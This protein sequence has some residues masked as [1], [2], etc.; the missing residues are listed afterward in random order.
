MSLFYIKIKG[1]IVYDNDRIK[2]GNEKKIEVA[3]LICKK[4][5]RE[6]SFWK[7]TLLFVPWSI[8]KYP[9]IDIVKMLSFLE[10]RHM[11]LWISFAHIR[12]L[13]FKRSQYGLNGTIIN[14]PL[15]FE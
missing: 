4:C 5:L 9:C 6:I 12:Q 1:G 7:S 8:R 2:I 3:E 10:E 14:V 13:G 15:K 11:P